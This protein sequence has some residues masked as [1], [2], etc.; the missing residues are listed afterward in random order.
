MNTRNFSTKGC[1]LLLLSLFV[2]ALSCTDHELPETPDNL[3]ESKC[4]AVD[5]SDRLYPCEF[6]IEKIDFLSK[7]GAV[8]AT[9]TADAQSIGIS[10][11]QAKTNTYAGNVE[12]QTG[13]ATFDIR[14]RIKRVASPSFPVN[15]GYLIGYTHNSSGKRILHTPSSPGDTYGERIKFGDPVTL[16]MAIGESRDV[17]VSML[18]PYKIENFGG[19]RPITIITS[20]SFFIDNDETT[21]A[22]P[23]A[24]YPYSQVGSVVEAYIEKIYIGITN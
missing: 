16:D 21:L 5:G 12:G 20:T 4:K 10:R 1:H 3:P 22:L 9:V 19:L 17:T 24:T 2:L 18:F 11:F 15:V 6:I 13:A 14:I 7:D 23:R 8:L